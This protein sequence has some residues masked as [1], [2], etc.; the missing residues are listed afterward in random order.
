MSIELE[1]ITVDVLSGKGEDLGFQ[2]K[3]H[4]LG[5]ESKNIVN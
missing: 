1:P 2:T 4:V 5:V 3:V